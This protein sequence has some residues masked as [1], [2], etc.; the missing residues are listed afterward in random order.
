M[1]LTSLSA[2]PS[3]Q[4]LN[5]DASLDLA[6]VSCSDSLAGRSR[7]PLVHSEIFDEAGLR[8]NPVS[9]GAAFAFD[10]IDQPLP[11]LG[12]LRRARHMIADVPVEITHCAQ[13]SGIRIGDLEAK[14]T[15]DFHDHLHNV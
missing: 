5:R 9:T 1:R 2:L 3:V 10:D 11:K 15:L 4:A 7:S 12:I 13:L 8:P 6:L 14:G